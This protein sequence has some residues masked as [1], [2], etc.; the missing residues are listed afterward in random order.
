MSKFN[1][2]VTDTLWPDLTIERD[3]LEAEG[4]EVILASSGRTPREKCEDGRQCDALIVNKNPMTRENLAVFEK[5]KILVRMGI[6]Y[7]EV[8]VPAAT[9]CGMIVCNVP[10]YCQH[11]V[12]DHTVALLLDVSRKIGLLS[13]QT[14]SG[15]WDASIATNVPRY[16]GKTLA[17]LGCGGIGCMVAK[18]IQGFGI[19][20]A[21]YDPYLPDEVFRENNIKKYD[22]VQDLLGIADFV[23]LHLPL[24]KESECIINKT[25]LGYMK[26]G[27]FLVN[28]SRGGLVNE[29]DLY[30]ALAGGH[31]EGAALDVLQKEPPTG[32]NRLAELDN[33][34]ITPHAAWNSIDALPELRKKVVLEIIR[35]MR[36]ERPNNVVNKDVLGLF[37]ELK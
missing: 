18:R 30:D 6:G 2:F 27:A 19:N 8:D 11:E 5:C 25:T 35:Y 28:T 13:R 33:V 1:V 3:M 20:V 22:R 24:T 36:G 23:S 29:D 17:L 4:A 16:E 15:G 14:R 37:P 34:I 7:N 10:D 9:E 12:A 26:Q 31:I 32:V 21:G